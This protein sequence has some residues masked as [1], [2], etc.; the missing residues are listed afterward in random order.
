MPLSNAQLMVPPNGPGVRGAVKAGSGITIDAVTGA[1]SADLNAFCSRILPGDNITILPNPG[2]GQ[3][4]I[5]ATIAPDP[6][7]LLPVGTVMTFFQTGAPPNWITEQLG[8]RMLRVVSTAGAGT[9][10]S[11]AWDAVFSSKTFTGSVSLSG[12]NASGNTTSASQVASGS[13]SLGGLSLGATSVSTAQIASHNHNYQP[14]PAGGNKMG[15]QQGIQDNQGDTTSA[16]GS[17]GGH[18]H[19]LSGS[20]SFSG[21]SYSHDHSFSAPV[22][23]NASF[24]GGSFDFSVQYID[25][26]VC[27]KLS[28]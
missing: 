20:G 18:S 28:N 21:N 17:S 10:G 9:G 13:I 12:V 22:T 26:I 27:R 16:T 2:L 15:Q 19:S 25:L 11:Q 23:G 6:T 24:S 3:V 8:T 7:K 1:V 14:R 5:S 4:T